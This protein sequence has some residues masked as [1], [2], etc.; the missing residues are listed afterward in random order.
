MDDVTIAVGSDHRGFPLK[1]AVM[2][3]IEGLGYRCL[4]MGCHSNDSVDYPDVAEKVA[5]A[6][7]DGE[8]G[9]GILVC[10]TGIGMS[11]AANKVPG[12]RA[13]LCPDPLSAEMARQHNDSNVLCMGGTMIGEWLAQEIVRAY[14]STEFEGGRHIRRLEKIR[15]LENDRR[16]QETVPRE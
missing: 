15:R 13:A 3:L 2:P 16:P 10:G 1:Q 4:D 5:R 12:V 14:L 7:A 8:A 11:I 9:Y 6:V